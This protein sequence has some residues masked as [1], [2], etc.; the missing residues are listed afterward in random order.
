MG[1]L[2]EQVK[3]RLARNESVDEIR[4]DMVKQG[5]LESDIDEAISN[6]STDIAEIKN[7]KESR[8]TSKALFKELFEK[9]GF[10][11]GSLQ[12]VNILFFLSGA[13]LFLIG[14]INGIRVLLI[15]LFN[16]LVKEYIN[17][18]YQHQ[19]SRN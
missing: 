18:R 4:V 9:F 8:L 13:S 11:F 5:F 10:G 16:P 7:K 1:K 3:E 2:D 6:A 12:Y 15:N 17:A 14:I 19:K